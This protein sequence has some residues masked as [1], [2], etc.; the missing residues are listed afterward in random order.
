M[1]YSINWAVYWLI[2]NQRDQSYGTKQHCRC[3][4][5]SHS[6]PSLLT[7]FKVD[8]SI[9]RDRN[10]LTNTRSV[11]FVVGSEGAL[12]AGEDQE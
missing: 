11:P 8:D 4:S 2:L 10:C 12:K 1:A 7:V 5:R 9:V 6:P 3:D